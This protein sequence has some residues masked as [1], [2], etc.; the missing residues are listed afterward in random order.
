MKYRRIVY[1][2]LAIPLSLVLMDGITTV[3]WFGTHPDAMDYS[4]FFPLHMQIGMWWL[5]LTLLSELALIG[6]TYAGFYLFMRWREP[7]RDLWPV[8]SAGSTLWVA[9][10]VGWAVLLNNL[11]IILTGTPILPYP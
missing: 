9:V 4:P 8:V 6:A 1:T 5:P 10:F 11:P 3:Y 7:D 2:L